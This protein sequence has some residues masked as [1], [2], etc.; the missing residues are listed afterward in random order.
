[1]P[2]S[3]VGIGLAVIG[4]PPVIGAAHRSRQHR[5]MHRAGE[6]PHARIQKGGIDAVQIH[7]RNPLMRIE[8][9]GAPVLIA[10]GLG[11]DHALPCAD[12]ADPAHTLPAAEDLL[13]DQQPLLAV[14]VDDELGRAVAKGRVDVVVP[15]SER[16]QDMAVRI[17]DVVYATHDLL[18]AQ[19]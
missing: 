15:Q 7:V 14:L 4:E 16:L 3:R 6:Q 13:L 9:A 5:I 10:H 2:N 19:W 8:A 12:P 18:L 1:M 17:D 11:R